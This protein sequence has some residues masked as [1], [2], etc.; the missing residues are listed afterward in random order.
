MD[1][2][3]SLLVVVESVLA[4]VAFELWLAAQCLT[5]TAIE[6][7]HHAVGLRS[8]R[9]NETML[10]MML[11]AHPVKRMRTTWFA[12]WLAFLVHC[13]AVCEASIVVGKQG[14]HRVGKRIQELT[15]T[16]RGRGGIA[17]RNDF[18]PDKARSP[19]NR[20]QHI[21]ALLLELAQHLEVHMDKPARGLL[22]TAEVTRL[23][24]LRQPVYA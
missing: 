7:L 16:L 17:A 1:E 15:Q 23:L 3:V 8:K 20:H 24:D 19:V 22:E 21:A 14:M 13:K 10:N 6:S 4:P 12:V 9:A 5:Q 18:H 2:L 11:T